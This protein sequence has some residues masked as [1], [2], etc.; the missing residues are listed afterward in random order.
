MSLS[1]IDLIRDKN[2][3]F[4][5]KLKINE[6]N[7]IGYKENMTL[8]KCCARILDKLST[9]FPQAVYDVLKVILEVDLKNTDWIIKYLLFI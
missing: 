6:L 5:D 3:F 7:Y 9:V 4:E 2:L 8:R 1:S